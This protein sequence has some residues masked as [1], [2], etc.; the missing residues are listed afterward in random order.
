MPYTSHGT[1]YRV[2]DTSLEAAQAIE[3]S[4]STILSDVLIAVS[5]APNGLTADECAHILNLSPLTVRPRFTELK[6]DGLIIPSPEKRKN[7]SGRRAQVW[8]CRNDA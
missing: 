2:S 6:R 4:V 8:V 5:S 7:R 3:P 1:G